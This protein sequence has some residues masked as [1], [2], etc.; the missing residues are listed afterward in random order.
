MLS[1]CLDDIGDDDTLFGKVVTENARKTYWL[2]YV[3]FREFWFA[4][5]KV[6]IL[7]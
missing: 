6:I 2:V 1:L 5:G 3:L 7:M 4:R